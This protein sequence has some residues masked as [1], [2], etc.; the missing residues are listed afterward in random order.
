M[1]NYEEHGFIDIDE[2]QRI[3]NE[4]SQKKY[5]TNFY[6][7]LNHLNKDL[8]KQTLTNNNLIKPIH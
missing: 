8:I 5:R 2:F 7:E 4:N 6:G 1:K 3:E